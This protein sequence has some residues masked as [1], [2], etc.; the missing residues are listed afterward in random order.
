MRFRFIFIS[1]YLAFSFHFANAQNEILQSG[2]MVGYSTMKEVALWVQTNQPAR[3][4]FE[5]WEKDKPEQ[6]WKTAIYQTTKEEA[7]TAQ[8]VAEVLP[9]RNY[10]YALYINERGVALP[11]E[12][13]FQSQQLWQWR[14][15]P[16]DF[17]FALGSCTY[18][19]EPEF[20]RPGNPY[21]G[22]YQIFQAM[23]KENPDF[24]L[25]LGDNMYLREVDWN[26]KKG[27]F[28]RYTHTRSTPEMQSFLA[29][30]HHY[31]VWD[32]HDY[33]PNDSDRGYWG[34]DW[35]F[36]AF[37]RFWANPNYNLTGKGGITGT[38]QWA[39]VQFFLLDNR[40]FRTP[41][42]RV[43]GEK[44]IICEEQMEWLIDALSFSQASFKFIVI[45]GQVLSPGA[46]YENHA[47]FGEERM[48]LIETIRA[49]QIPGVI[50]L[51]GDRHH[52]E[53]TR[54]ALD[55]AYPLY[56]FTV[57][58]LTSGAGNPREDENPLRVEGSLVKQRN[59]G[60]IEVSGPRNNRVLKMLLKDSEGNLLW[61]YEIAQED[62]K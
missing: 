57:S 43:T 16:P 9:G 8:L 20:D 17:S 1:L 41:N 27:I 26:S 21:G 53:L 19:N 38:F 30:T 62:L 54:Y 35:T 6:R 7:Y 48:R 45:G 24:M 23:D 14:T 11:Y 56:D 13:E 34:K 55:R 25:W 2:P 15:D 49:E 52:S 4:H 61:T 44:C 10:H 5:Y 58:P 40:W 50:F 39:D 47:Q 28:D 12:L 3:V 46:V 31:A 42:N 59:Y 33:G 60:L 22:D 36:E 51:S 18:I 32:D 37:T 29:G